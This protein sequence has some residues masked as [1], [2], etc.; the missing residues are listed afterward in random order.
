MTRGAC[1]G[2]WTFLSLTPCKLEMPLTPRLPA[3][4]SFTYFEGHLGPQA[5]SYTPIRKSS[6]T[7]GRTWGLRE[8]SLTGG[9]PGLS[10]IQRIREEGEMGMG[11]S[12]DGDLEAGRTKQ[13]GRRLKVDNWKLGPQ[14]ASQHS[15][16]QVSLPVPGQGKEGGVSSPCENES[17]DSSLSCSFS[18]DSP[19]VLKACFGVVVVVFNGCGWK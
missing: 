6:W 17:W 4:V 19:S 12:G 8:G 14:L 1:P 9:S 7:V 11:A 10:E 5:S 2:N 3:S 18:R 15:D 16:V 13:F